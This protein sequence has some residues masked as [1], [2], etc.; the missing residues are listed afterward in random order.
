MN[1]L[2]QSSKDFKID[3]DDLY[4]D[5]YLTDKNWDVIK[6]SYEREKESPEE[7]AERIEQERL[8]YESNR[9]VY[10][11][12]EEDIYEEEK[13]ETKHIE[14]DNKDKKTFRDKMD[15]LV[16]ENPKRNKLIKDSINDSIKNWNS[17]YLYNEYE[18]A[19]SDEVSSESEENKNTFKTRAIEDVILPQIEENIN[20]NNYSEEELKR[21][22]D[23]KDKF[24]ALKE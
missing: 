9:E 16:N 23:L 5:W 10:E 19:I 24:T 7:V 4:A 3:S 1:R 12:T 22:N 15:E 6:P 2:E 13:Y 21:I 18:N 14:E 11:L 20:T 8:E 17:D